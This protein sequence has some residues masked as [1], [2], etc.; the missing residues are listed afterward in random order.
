MVY[1]PTSALKDDHT[2]ATIQV[3]L[4]STFAGAAT[5][6]SHDSLTAVF[7]TSPKENGHYL[8]SAWFNGVTYETTTLTEGHKLVLIYDVAKTTL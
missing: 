1:K 4:P 5:R 2:F 6:L 7:D 8:V 3:T